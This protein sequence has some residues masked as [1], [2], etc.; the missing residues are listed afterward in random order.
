MQI[1]EDLTKGSI[2]K[3]LWR[4]ALPITI[5]FFFETMFNFTDAFY[6]GKVSSHALA[7]LGATFPLFFTIIA[8]TAGFGT[9]LTAII[10]HYVGGK[11]EKEAKEYASYGL[12]L[13]IYIAIAMM[14]VGFGTYQMIFRM[15][16]LSPEGLFYATQYFSVLL[17]A[18]PFLVLQ[19]VGNSILNARGDTKTLGIALVVGAIMNM[20]LDPAFM[21]GW[22]PIPK[23]GFTGIATSTVF[24]LILNSLFVMYRAFKKNSIT[25]SFKFL[26]PN[27]PVYKEI[28]EQGLP[29]MLSLFTVAAGALLITRFVAVFGDNAIAGFTTAVRIEQIA[30]LPTI[31]INIAV[32][33]MVAQYAGAGMH[34]RIRDIVTT[35]LR[36][37]TFVIGSL[38]LILLLFAKPLLGIFSSSEEI[39]SIGYGY[40]IAAVFMSLFS[41]VNF[42][43][44]ATLR[45]LKRP[46]PSLLIGIGRQIILPFM[47]IPLFVYFFHAPWAIWLGLG[48]SVCIGALI[49][50]GY[51]RKALQRAEA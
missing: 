12:G 31:G 11:K 51:V 7:A 23:M 40:I 35:A 4:V 20:I 28:L 33:A 8:C 24:V 49:S 25:W 13:G 48:L 15:I 42:I 18:V 43:C 47:I 21:Y 6:A 46:I 22:G 2:G 27:W 26:R 1:E 39:V 17:F 32:L 36:T 34:T 29:S 45:G 30:L 16:G 9:G 37:G 19:F 3:T 41:L 38:M 14:L 50:S 44:D 5:G 10:G